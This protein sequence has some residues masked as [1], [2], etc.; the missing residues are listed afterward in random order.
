MSGGRWDYENDRLAHEIFSW[1]LDPD[2]GEDGFKQSVVARKINP[3]EDK[4]LSEML[5]DML[6]LLHSY[7]W[8]ASGDCCEDSY[9]KDV[10]YFKNKWLK[11]QAAD[12]TRREIDETIEEAR[13]ELY[14]TFGIEDS[15][16]T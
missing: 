12:Q 8:Y 7:D 16:C 4:Q 10:A 6:C 9:R 3:L 1:N 13:R 2:Y 15:N 14:R 5:W 11:P